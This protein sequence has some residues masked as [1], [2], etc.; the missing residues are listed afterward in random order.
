MKVGD[1]LHAQWTRGKTG[2]DTL[3][4]RKNYVPAENPNPVTQPVV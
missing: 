3:V 2:F 4:L 1:Q